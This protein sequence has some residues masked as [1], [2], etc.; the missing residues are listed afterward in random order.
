MKYTLCEV[1][2]KYTYKKYTSSILYAYSFKYMSWQKI[3]NM[4]Y[5]CIIILIAMVW[6]WSIYYRLH[7]PLP[8]TIS[9]DLSN[10]TTDRCKYS[11]V[12]WKTKNQ[13]HNGITINCNTNWMMT[14]NNIY[15]DVYTYYG[16][17]TKSQL[18]NGKRYS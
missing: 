15:V 13:F 6:T 18:I 14:L 2:F 4:L 12:Y 10:K 1:Y 7:V 8:G 11:Q 9:V 3:L 17:S 16:Q 5:W